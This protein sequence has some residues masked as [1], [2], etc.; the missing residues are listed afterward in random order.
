M[1]FILYGRGVPVTFHTI[2]EGVPGAF[3]TIGGYLVHFESILHLLQ[4]NSCI[5]VR[6]CIPIRNQKV[7]N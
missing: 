1:H 4:T 7:V 2:G 6:V 5:S 3:H